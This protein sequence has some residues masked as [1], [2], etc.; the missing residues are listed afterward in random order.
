MV[1]IEQAKAKLKELVEEFASASKNKEYINSQN[2]EWI[3]WNFLEPL[4]ENVFGCNKSDIE[5]EKR[6]LKGRADYMLKLGNE[7]V[8]V[9]EAKKAGVSLSE[10]EGRQAVSYAYHRK[11]KFAI[12]TNFKE[13]RV[14]HA[15]TNL[16]QIDH[17]LLKFENGGLFRFS[18]EQFVDNIDKLML[19]S[20]ESFEGKKINK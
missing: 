6:I 16:K 1:D 13:I 14:Y 15:L 8:L 9:V 3:K 5:K 11:V 12:V 17:N 20:R 18:F 2:E 4:L 7:E 10:E 19:L